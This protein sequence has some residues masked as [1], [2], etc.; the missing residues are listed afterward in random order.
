MRVEKSQKGESFVFS[1]F[2]NPSIVSLTNHHRIS[3]LR[4]EWPLTCKDGRESKKWT[5]YHAPDR[6]LNLAEKSLKEF[7]VSLA[8]HKSAKPGD[9]GQNIIIFNVT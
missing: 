2:I 5:G 1:S 4:K 7:K 6:R 8:A 9:V 3:I